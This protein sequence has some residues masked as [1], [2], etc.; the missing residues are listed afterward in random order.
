LEPANAQMT[1]L[2]MIIMQ[3]ATPGLPMSI[4]STIGG[5]ELIC[6]ADEY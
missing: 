6:Y 2:G 1:T 4:T 3:A 5:L